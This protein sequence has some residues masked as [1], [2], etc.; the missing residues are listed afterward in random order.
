MSGLDNYTNKEYDL[1]II[2]GGIHGAGIAQAAAAA[3]YSVVLL[4]KNELGSATSSSSSKLIHG[5]LR[6]LESGQFSLVRE[7]LKDR[8]LLLRLAPNLVKMV[9]FYIPVYKHSSRSTFKISIGLA[10]YALF[11][12]LA[13]EY[14][15]TRFSKREWDNEDKL[16]S[17][18]LQ[19]VFQYWDA[20]T[21]DLALTRAVAHSAK[22]LGANIITQANVT[23]VTLGNDNSTVCFEH[24]N[25]NLSV[26]C[27][28]VINASG[29]WVNNTL[30][31]V[32]PKPD[33]LPVDLVQGTHIL[34][35]RVLTKGIYY[36]ESR[37]DKRAVFCMPWKHKTL[38]GTTETIFKGEP[39]KCK[40][41]KQEIDYLVRVYN[42]YFPERKLNEENIIDAFS[43]LR[44]LARDTNDAF[45]RSRDVIITSFPDIE[46]RLVSVYGGKL[47]AY[48]STAEK[49]LASIKKFLPRRKRIADPKK[50]KLHPLNTDYV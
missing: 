1:A 37:T 46:P 11:G 21:D 5:G 16:L 13:P 39:G 31:L 24:N 8:S 3:G 4:E 6:Y 15:F 7:C 49:V 26:I 25:D 45:F 17:T 33:I 34:V 23:G 18:G 38:I 27:R 28:F 14:L 42:D 12:T 19:A 22:Q 41:E 30:A 32:S 47:T 2:G 36:I 9:P 10:I 44:V 48:L 20:Q 40:P 29:P 50:L 43:G 35:D